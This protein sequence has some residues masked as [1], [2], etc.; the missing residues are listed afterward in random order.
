MLARR[1][2]QP[3]KETGHAKSA[4]IWLGKPGFDLFKFHD[5][6]D[7]A[8]EEGTSVSPAFA[9]VIHEKQ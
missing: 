1:V 4:S 2:A 7:P 3:A 5:A 6:I 8:T 9:R